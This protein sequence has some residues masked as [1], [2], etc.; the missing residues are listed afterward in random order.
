MTSKLLLKLSMRRYRAKLAISSHMICCSRLVVGEMQVLSITRH[1]LQMTFL[2]T[3][4]TLAAD[5]LTAVSA[6][7]SAWAEPNPPVT[8]LKI[9]R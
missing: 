9:K 2:A 3:K 8:D 7:I 4:A 6:M 1:S 5:K